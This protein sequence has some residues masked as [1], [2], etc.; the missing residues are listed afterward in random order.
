MAAAGAGLA[1]SA[2]LISACSGTTY[3]TGVT[4][5]EQLVRDLTGALSLAPE[6][7]E[8]IEYSPRPGIVKPPSTEVLPPPQESVATPENPAWPESPEERLARVRAE[9][10]ANQDNPL[11]RPN[12]IRDLDNDKPRPQTL[13]V[14]SRT[15]EEQRQEFLRRRQLATQGDPTRRR[16]LSDP[17]TEYRQPAESAPVGELGEDEWKK[18]RAAKRAAAKESGGLRR[19]IPWLN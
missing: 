12:I 19:L 14:D 8:P 5:E 10:T 16:Y 13:S 7:K 15:R 1:V 3:G 2:M 4:S 9:A 6:K 17:P 18:E 11:Y